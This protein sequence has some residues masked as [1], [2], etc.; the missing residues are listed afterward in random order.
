VP[1]LSHLTSCTLTKS[2]LYLDSSIKTVIK[3]PVLYILRV[4]HVPNHMSFF[5]RLGCLSKES[6]QVQGSYKSFITN[7]YFYGERLLAPRP[8]SRLEDHSLSFVHGCQFI[9]LASTPHSSGPSLQPQT[10]DVPCCSD[11]GTHITW[12]FKPVI[13]LIKT[14]FYIRSVG[15]VRLRTKVHG[16]CFCFVILH[17]YQ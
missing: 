4:F 3:E 16:V 5:H 2:N 17:I 1:L 7:L 15:I 10:K 13:F 12:I 14:K 8:T 9:V 6:V 11:E